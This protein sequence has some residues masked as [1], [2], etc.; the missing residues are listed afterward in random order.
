[1][2]KKVIPMVISLCLICSISVMAENTN[3]TNDGTAPEVEEQ[4]PQRKQ[5]NIQMP[6]AD[7]MQGRTPPSMPNGEM[8]PE[9]MNRGQ[10]P[11]G[12][13]DSSQ[14]SGE[15]VP[16][17]N[18]E[19]NHNSETASPQTEGNTSAEN[20][21]TPGDNQQFDGQI[22]GGMGGFPGN[23][24]NFNQNTQTEQETGFLGFVKTNSTPI[25]SV[26]LLALAFAFVVFYRRKNY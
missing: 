15:F 8:S 17:Q 18:N 25:T 1:M 14:N 26:I 2:L 24:Q 11:S 5:G 4:I 23:M 20:S 7:D 16:P 21:Q 9:G 3:A 13:H 10:R 22:P 6:P 12:N 19:A